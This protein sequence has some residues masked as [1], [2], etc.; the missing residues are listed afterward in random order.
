[1]ERNTRQGINEEYH[2]K[3]GPM[4]IS[5]QVEPHEITK[6]ILESIKNLGTPSTNDI[7]GENQE[8]P[9]VVQVHQKNGQRWS[10]ADGYLSQSVLDRPNF[11]LQFNAFVTKVL[12]KGKQA[13]GV[14]YT[15]SGKTI[16]VFANKEVILSG[17]S[18][19]TPQILLLSGVGPKE[20]L[21][22][23]S[24]ELVHDLKGVGKNLQDHVFYTICHNTTLPSV[25]TE[26]NPG[27]IYQ[28]AS[29]GKGPLTSNIGEGASFHRT[30]HVKATDSPNLEYVVGPLY[31]INHGKVV[32]PGD[33]TTLGP[34]LLKPKSRG[35]ITLASK[36]PTVK[37]IIQPNYFSDPQDLEVLVEAFH[38][39]RKIYATKPIVD[40]LDT[41]LHPGKHVQSDVQIKEFI[42]NSLMTIY[43]PTS[44]CKM[45]PKSDVNAVV[46]EKL[47]IHGLTGIR[48][49]DASIFPNVPTGHTHAPTTMV[50]EKASDLIKEDWK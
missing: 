34:I 13:I 45:G 44:T 40:H 27:T 12:F 18:I 43:H 24:I 37:P 49:V 25:H 10:S 17:G 36:D 8:G 48:V 26:E 29:A 7:N 42:K 6:K 3:N 33:G 32:Y 47:K 11:S 35:E 16:Q 1:M 41:E 46:D 31:F 39:A 28:W 2:G 14:E 20:E 50:G 9:S 38:S 22:K 23:L 5:D 4:Y 19:N 21:E 15:Q 30:S